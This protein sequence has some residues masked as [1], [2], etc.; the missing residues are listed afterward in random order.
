MSAMDAKTKGEWVNLVHDGLHGNGAHFRARLM[1]L[2]AKVRKDSPELAEVLAE[3]VQRFSPVTQELAR[4]AAP[5]FVNPTPTDHDT[6]LPLVAIEE[7]PQLQNEPIWPARVLDQLNGVRAEWECSDDLRQAGLQPARTLLLSG[8]PGTGKTLAAR[9][10][11]RELKRPLVSLNLASV[12][13]SFLGKT[14]QNLARVLTYGRS[15]DCVLLL[16]EFDALAKR[17]DD[18]QDVGELKRVVNVLL[19][20]VDEWPTTSLLVAATNHPELLDR[21]MF[22]RFDQ[23]VEFPPVSR[24]Q[25]REA[26]KQLDVSG[27]MRERLARS[28]AGKPLSDTYRLVRQANKEHVLKQ[29]TFGAALS[30]IWARHTSINPRES[31]DAEIFA[32]HE[33]GL[34]HRDIARQF[35]IAHTTV[36]RIVAKMEVAT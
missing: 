20:A 14:G 27:P 10:L 33:Q 25:V 3:A 11:A 26:L 24:A 7:S 34:S 31:R 16:D 36:S 5:G 13:N 35:H 4:D 12:M 23:V 30:A 19:Q 8:P 15:T 29:I 2:L 21:A 18:S 17:R 28:M 22:R 1:R 9:W 32:L 6:K